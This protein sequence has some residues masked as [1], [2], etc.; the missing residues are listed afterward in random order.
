MEASFWHQK[1]EKGDIGFHQSE[2]N[3]LLIKH[4]EGLNLA[5]GSRIFLPLCGKTRDFA[6]LLAGGYRVVGA[7]LSELAI[8]D[9]FNDLGIEPEISRVEKLTRYCAKDIDILVGDIFDVSVEVLG[10]VDAIYD[11]AAL[12]AMPA[13]MR[14]QYTSHLIKITNAAP[15]LLIC[16]EYDEQLMDGPPFSVNEAEVKRH[17][18]AAYRLNRVEH[19][20]GGRRL[21]GKVASIETVWLLQKP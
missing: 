21:K 15:Q 8:N 20:D 11:R 12:V 16:Y 13:D 17:Y 10:L 2:A 5:K 7:E 6:W 9:L 19:K 1:W 4:F 18:A 14:N 3:A